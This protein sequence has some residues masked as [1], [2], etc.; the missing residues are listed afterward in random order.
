MKALN[1]VQTVA[2]QVS[3]DLTIS[4]A[5]S[6]SSNNIIVLQALNAFQNPQHRSLGT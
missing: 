3:I 1:M 4:L 6:N 2:E 5:T